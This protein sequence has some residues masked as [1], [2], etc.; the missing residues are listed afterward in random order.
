MD[1]QSPALLNR[2]IECDKIIRTYQFGQTRRD[3]SK[4]YNNVMFLNNERDKALVEC[5]RLGRT[6][7]EYEKKQSELEL[8]L[9]NLESYITMAIL[10]KPE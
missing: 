4:M 5:R 7:S 8:A 10:I 2:I 1:Y 3:L 6:T 9:E